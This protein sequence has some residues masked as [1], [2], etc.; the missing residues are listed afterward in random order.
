MTLATLRAYLHKRALGVRETYAD[1]Y[2]HYKFEQDRAERPTVHRS[3]GDA[4]ILDAMHQAQEDQK[5]QA[6]ERQVRRYCEA[7]RFVTRPSKDAK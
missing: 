3:H 1:L 6:V 7:S 2:R 5:R 4:A